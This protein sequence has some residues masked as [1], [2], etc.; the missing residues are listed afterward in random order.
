MKLYYET[1]NSLQ[2]HGIKG[3]KWGVR[4]FQNKDGTLT[5]KG[6]KRYNTDYSAEAKTMSDEELRSRIARLSNEKKYMDLTRKQ[7]KLSKYGDKIQK[8][9]DI[10]SKSIEAKKN[11]SKLRNTDASQYEIAGQG[12]KAVS[13]TVGAAKKIDKMVND[14]KHVK[15]SKEQLNT[16]SD[17]ELNEIVA[18]LDLEKRYSDVSRE[19]ASRGKVTA[20]QILDVAGDTLAIAASVTG[21]LVGIKA[22][23]KK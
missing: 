17:K 4:R 2:H 11:L 1:P 13:K 20:S 9:A 14:P 21:I 8:K 18:R 23:T 3:Q 16:L 19:V 7:T 12:V 5:A 15:K 10:A 6:K 22:L